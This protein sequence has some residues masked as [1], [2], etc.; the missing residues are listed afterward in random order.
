MHPTAATAQRRHRA[1]GADAARFW[2]AVTPALLVFGGFVLYPIGTVVYFSLTD[3]DGFR[4]DYDFVG[5]EN[6]AA[7]LAGDPAIVEAI[8]HTLVYG[9]FYIVVQTVVAFGLAVLMTQVLRGA[10]FYRSAFFLPVVIS[11]VAV[12]FTWQFLLDPN[13][14]SINEVLRAVGLGGLAQDWLGNYDLALYSVIVVD[15]WR[16]IGFS[17]VIFIA[18]LST[19][20][21]ELQEAAQVDGASPLRVLRHIT[22]PL[23][24]PTLAL[25]VVL[26]ANGALRAF[27]TVYL[28]TGGG[29]GTATQLYMTLAFNKAFVVRDFGMSAAMS[30]LV[31]LVLV[32]LAIAQSRLGGD[33]S[34]SRAGRAAR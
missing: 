11:A 4:S 17:I 15:L 25:V 23:L 9:F 32:P 5:L 6:Y 19:I 8:G 7:I 27:D 18:G 28:M 30:L 34:G 24:G 22:I 10:S 33:R 26:A 20:P 3:Y 13:T 12:A 14:G 31:V 21:Q 1:R 29:P 16:N 2:L